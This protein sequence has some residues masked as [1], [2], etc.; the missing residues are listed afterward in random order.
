MKKIYKLLAA[1]CLLLAVVSLSSCL[2]DNDNNISDPEKEWK[3]WM[4]ALN[5]E[6][7]AAPGSYAGYM[8]Y[9]AETTSAETD[10]IA[11]V[12]D[13]VNDSL[14]VLRNVP[15][16]LFVQ[17]L[18]ESQ[19]TLKEAISAVNTV[20][21]RVK[22]IYNVYYRSPLL[23]Y[24]YPE[25]VT[26]NITVDGQPKTAV[27]NFMNF[28]TA[29]QSYGQVMVSDGRCAVN[30]FLENIVVDKSIVKTFSNYDYV[31]LNWFGKKR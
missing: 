31:Y 1:G 30:M 23:F 21:V 17:K 9:Q 8:Y 6:I 3:E 18:P 20:D 28:E 14:M 25:P 10:S 27:V 7:A 13:I 22:I 11:A 19:S 24:V 5:A 12:W 16:R 26:L 4:E 2:S 29:N 15:T